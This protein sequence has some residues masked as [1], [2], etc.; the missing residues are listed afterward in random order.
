MICQKEDYYEDSHG[1][2]II[3]KYQGL[4]FA[5]SGFGSVIKI[6]NDVCFQETS[7]Y[8]H[9]DSKIEI[10]NNVHFQETKIYVH[11]DSKI[12]ISNNVHFQETSIGVHNNSGIVIGDANCIQNCIVETGNSVNVELKNE[13]N[14]SGS[15]I[16]I[17]DNA[18]LKIEQK[19][20]IQYGSFSMKEYSNVLIGENVRVYGEMFCTAKWTLFEKASLEIGNHGILQTGKI[21]LYR[22]SSMQ[23]GKE[24]SIWENYFLFLDHDT[25]ITIG[26]DCMF[27]YNVFIFSGDLHSIFDVASGKNI[28]STDEICKNRKIHIGNHVWLG[29][30]VTILYNTQIGDGSIIGAAGLVK[31]TIPN[32]CIAAGNPAKV[33]RKN[34]SWSR[35]NGAENIAECG[36]QYVNYTKT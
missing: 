34:V 7:I 20:F 25:S 8:V 28:N 3:G 11:N 18:S 29:M 24:F 13:V 32:N 1:N 2:R 22:N 26:N 16:S 15:N 5:F 14:L 35:H 21:R 12:E 27:S 36:Y 17:C 19:S 33:T 30:R 10:S 9:N 31:G 4:K 6:G 23:I